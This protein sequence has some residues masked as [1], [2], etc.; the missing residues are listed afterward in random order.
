MR[1]LI[2]DYAGHPFQVQLSRALAARGH[3]VLHLYAAY[4]PTPKGALAPSDDDPEGFAVEGL[5]I[6][7]TYVR[8]SFV[9]RWRQERAYGRVLA[10]RI[11]A[12]APEVAFFCNTPLDTLAIAQGACRRAGA[13]FV[14]WLQDLSGIA[15]Q[16]ILRARLPV[17]GAL[18]GRYHIALERRIAR[19]SDPIVLITADFEPLMRRWGIA[20]DRLAVIEN[21]SP[22]DAIH[23]APRDNA[24]S[25]EHGLDDRLVI[26]YTGMMGLKHNPSLVGDLATHL[27][28]RPEV[29]IVVVSEG[30]GA[31]WLAAYKAREGLETLHLLAFQRMSEVLGSADVLLAILEAD[32][33][34]YSVPSKVLGYLC[35]GRAILASVPPENLAARILNGHEAGLTVDAD[36][37]PGLAAAA[38]R[39][40]GAPALR[41]RLG[42]N[43]LEYAKR[44]FDIDAITTRFEAVIARAAK[45]GEP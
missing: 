36:D 7:E 12:W 37:A 39:L 22:L 24:W 25:R 27:K 33:G 9:T 38:D 26:L 10:R 32:A 19:R 23:P 44:T 31:D 11:A 21:W 35:A 2:H 41:E 17:I 14:F 6:G 42:Q 18:I 20:G 28:A 34:V 45:G 5:T 1:I 8:Y 13:R 4:N 3:T 43:G 15:A 30:L 29:A 16:R 40:I